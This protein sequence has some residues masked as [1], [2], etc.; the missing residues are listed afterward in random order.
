M[1]FVSELSSEALI[2]AELKVKDYKELIKCLY[3]DKPN[4]IIF[5][6][7][8]CEIFSKITNRTLDYFKNLNI[9]DLFY[10]LL[11]VR[12]NSQGEVCKTIITK[13][14]KKMNLDLRLDYIRDDIKLNFGS[15]LI[16]KQNNI[17]IVLDYPSVQRLLQEKTEDYLYFIKGVFTDSFSKKFIEIKNNK[18]ANLLFEKI[19]PKLSLEIINNINLLIERTNNTNF[20]LRYGIKDQKLTFAPS[21]DSLIWFAKL[22]FSEDLETFYNNIFHL[23]HLGHMSSEYIEN[24]AVGEYIYFVNCLKNTLTTNETVDNNM[25]DENITDEEA[26]LSDESI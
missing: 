2:C 6:E 21:L 26:G 18:E 19:P 11:D 14:N 7:T 9:V 4:K 16:V 25:V 5:I 15:T 23:S 20:L 1:K 24:S 3:E 22:I 12:V 13:E 8:I 10:L 17:Q